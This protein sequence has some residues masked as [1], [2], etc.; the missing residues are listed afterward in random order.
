MVRGRPPTVADRIGDTVSGLA[1]GGASPFGD[2]IA[3]VLRRKKRRISPTGTKV[4]RSSAT[5]VRY[6]AADATEAAV[7]RD[8]Q[9]AAC[10]RL[11]DTQVSG[12]GIVGEGAS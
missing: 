7:E 12:D 11:R 2:I 10:R 1:Q 6:R 9:A 8:A 5:D 4:A 3:T